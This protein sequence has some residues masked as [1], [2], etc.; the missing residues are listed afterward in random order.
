MG[1]VQALGAPGRPQLGPAWPT[2]GA[3]RLCHGR[4]GRVGPGGGLPVPEG[5][6]WPQGHPRAEKHDVK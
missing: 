5:L 4:V 1:H 6:C 2:Q 3:S